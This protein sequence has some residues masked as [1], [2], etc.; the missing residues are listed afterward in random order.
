MDP[1][2]YSES[3]GP[4]WN[5]VAS[6]ITTENISPRIYY[7]LQALTR[8]YIERFVGRSI[9]IEWEPA[10]TRDLRRGQIYWKI[11]HIFDESQPIL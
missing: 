2:P 9:Y 1:P 7:A 3:E 5:I 10:S 6:K 4:N 11:L 8:E